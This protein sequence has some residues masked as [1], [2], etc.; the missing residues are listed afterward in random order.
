MHLRVVEVH[1]DGAVVGEQRHEL[2]DAVAH[3]RQPDRVLVV[4]VVLVKRLASVEGRVDV[5]QPNLPSVRLGVLG[6]PVERVER[7]ICVTLDEEAVGRSAQYLA[8]SRCLG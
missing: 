4:V 8:Y 1:P 7:V 2:T 6:D 3:H 5:D